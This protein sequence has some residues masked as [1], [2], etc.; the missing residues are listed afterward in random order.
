MLVYHPSILY[1]INK[2]GVYKTFVEAIFLLN[3]SNI[4]V[5][6]YLLF[7]GV[8]IKRHTEQPGLL[9]IRRLACDTTPTNQNQSNL[10][11]SPSLGVRDQTYPQHRQSNKT[12]IPH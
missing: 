5:I 4:L 3:H 11:T 12:I 7:C 2:L 8:Q 6:D 9:V 1:G 10:E